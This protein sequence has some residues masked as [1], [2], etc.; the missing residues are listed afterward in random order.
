MMSACNLPKF[1][2]TEAFKRAAYIVNRLLNKF[3]PETPLE[4][5]I[6]RKP[7]LNHVRVWGYLVE[8]KIITHSLK[9]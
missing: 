2:W 8:V 3:V 4:L 5:Q 9:R 1:F 7:S 6:G